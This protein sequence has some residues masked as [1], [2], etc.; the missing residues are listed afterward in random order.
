M[1]APQDGDFLDRFPTNL[2]LIVHDSLSRC[3]YAWCVYSALYG[4]CGYEETI[5][6]AQSDIYC[7][8]VTLSDIYFNFYIFQ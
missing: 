2:E 8:K 1:K 3:P 5:S 7:M 4:I 6:S